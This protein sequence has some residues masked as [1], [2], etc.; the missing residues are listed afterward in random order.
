MAK[1]YFKHFKENI[2]N[3]NSL[4][5]DSAFIENDVEN[6]QE[7]NLIF[8]DLL[9]SSLPA[10][11]TP[12]YFKF[13]YNWTDEEAIEYV[14]RE[15]LPAATEIE[16]IEKS[17]GKPYKVKQ[18]YPHAAP[19]DQKARAKNKGE[20]IVTLAYRM[21]KELPKE[22][23]QQGREKIVSVGG[24]VELGTKPNKQSK[25]TKKN[26]KL[27]ANIFGEFPVL[28]ELPSSHRIVGYIKLRN[29][30]TYIA[31]IKTKPIIVLWWKPAAVVA[32]ASL[33]VILLMFKG[34]K[35]VEPVRDIFENL[36]PKGDGPITVVENKLPETQNLRIIMN[37]SITLHNGQMNIMLENN[38]ESNELSMVAEV[39]LLNRVD[40]DGNKIEPLGNIKIAQTP[41][42]HPGESL[43]YL[44][45]LDGVELAP[46]YYDAR[47]LFTAYE[48]VEEGGLPVGQVAGRISLLVTENE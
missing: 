12:E 41:I 2:S 28:R 24:Y 37:Q 47:V 36:I 9:E 14:K 48:I 43:E 19:I 22:K 31:L 46:G 34:P 26:K 35:I 39:Y 33:V 5:L 4:Q 29:T 3:L 40:R 21:L 8:V 17:T 27:M 15:G 11:Q 45:S 32:S 13:Y 23:D 25:I 7:Q 6:T 44:P 18:A 10:Y 1:Y 16:G 30:D 20:Q 42:I 38:K